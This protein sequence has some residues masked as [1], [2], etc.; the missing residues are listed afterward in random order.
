MHFLSYL[1]QFFSEWE[2]FQTNVVQKIKTHILCSVTFS[3][4]SCRLW[5][6][7]EKYCRAVQDTDYNMAHF[8]ANLSRKFQFHYTLPTITGT[9]HADRYTFFIISRSVLLRMRNVSD[10]SC[11]ENWNSHF[12]SSNVFSKIVP[13]MRY[14]GKILYSGSEN[15]KFGSCVLN[16]G[17]LR[18][19][20]HT[21]RLCNHYCFPL[22]KWLHERPS[23]LRYNFYFIT[24]VPWI[25]M[26]SKSFTSI[27]QLMHNRVALKEY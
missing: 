21:L 22:Q 8:F 19:Q 24:V 5:D 3:R 7:V 6:N 14:C 27:Y 1:A 13:F 23:I 11:R 10:K 26:V 4:K 9:S 16:A 25:L 20:T 12:I 2:M 18:L 17:Y 15:W